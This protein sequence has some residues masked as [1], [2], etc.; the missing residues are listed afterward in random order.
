MCI[1]EWPT[2]VGLASERGGGSNLTLANALT[3]LT[4]I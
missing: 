2:M 1:Y 4:R 3:E